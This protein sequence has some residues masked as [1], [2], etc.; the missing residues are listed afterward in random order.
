[1]RGRPG[2]RSIV[3]DCAGPAARAPV[4]AQAR[5]WQGRPDGPEDLEWVAAQAQSPE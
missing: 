2:L 3:V 1:M 5:G 4:W